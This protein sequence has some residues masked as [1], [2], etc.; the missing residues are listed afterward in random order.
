MTIR[1]SIKIIMNSD[2]SK[3]TVDDFDYHLPKELIAF[4]PCEKRDSS[5]LLVVS[6]SSDTFVDQTFSQLSS[7]MKE[8]DLLV[9]N[10]TKVFPAR[11]FGKKDSGGKVE[12][13]AERLLDDNLVKVQLKSNRT[14]KRG[15]NI[16]INEEV[17]AEVHG[18]DE[19]FFIVKFI[20]SLSALEIFE[21][22]GHIP[23]PPY[24]DRND[25]SHDRDRYQTVYANKT[26]AVAAPTAGLHFTEALLQ[27][28]RDK[29]VLVE[30]ITL[31]VGAGTF[32]PVKVSDP[33]QHKMHAEYA[34]VSRSICEKIQNVKRLGGR[35]FAVGTTCVRALETAAQNGSI[36]SYEGETD[37]FIYPGFT[38]NV[39]DALITN[40]HLPRSTLLMLVS[41]LAG[42]DKIQSAYQYAINHQYRFYS[43]GDAML[44]HP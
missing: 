19:E 34:Q 43:Y 29:G 41:A 11:L 8:G 7:W 18:R 40:F 4:E 5:Q 3:F 1:L 44:I 39:V 37:I 26:G 12:I 30:T 27:E 17:M 42:K 22:F 25:E 14:L 15:A 33:T 31:H 21:K 24:I 13:L 28:L 16:M 23:L 6:Q 36:S 35:V 10:D 20:S 32:K 38:F 9:L 2:N